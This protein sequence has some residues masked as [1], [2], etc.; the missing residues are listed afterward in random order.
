MHHYQ[1]TD[2]DA[3]PG[4]GVY[5]DTN[6]LVRATGVPGANGS[7]SEQ[8]RHAS[9]TNGQDASNIILEEEEAIPTD[10]GDYHDRA[11]VSKGSAPQSEAGH[12]LLASINSSWHKTLPTS[13]NQSTQQEDG[14]IDSEGYPSGD[15]DLTSKSL[16]PTYTKYHQENEYHEFRPIWDYYQDEYEGTSYAV[17]SLEAGSAEKGSA[18]DNNE[19]NLH[20]FMSL[21]NYAWSIA[22]SVSGRIKSS[23]MVDRCY[24]LLVCEAHRVGRAWGDSGTL[25]ASG[26][27]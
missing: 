20:P 3:L 9:D 2:I 1:E 26:L 22:T 16:D 8:T 18:S 4:R 25:L 21:G 19:L 17:P 13:A 15:T 5:W 14:S 10:Y 12:K 24:E 23:V 6:I 11:L 27:R 7:T